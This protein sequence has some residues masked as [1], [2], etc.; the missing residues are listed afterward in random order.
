MSVSP[1][2]RP[3]HSSFKVSRLLCFHFQISPS[4]S[5]FSFLL[6]FTSY[7]ITP[8]TPFCVS[9]SLCVSFPLISFVLW[10]H[11]IIPNHISRF[12]CALHIIF[13]YTRYPLSTAG[14]HGKHLL[15]HKFLPPPLAMHPALTHKVHSN[16][17]RFKH[18]TMQSCEVD[19][20]NLHGCPGL[21]DP[22]PNYIHW[23]NGMLWSHGCGNWLG[24]DYLRLSDQAHPVKM[25]K[26][27]DR[28]S[29]QICCF[30]NI[31]YLPPAFSSSS[32]LTLIKLV[33][34]N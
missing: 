3:A 10:P 30:R 25:T 31:F 13:R 8:F 4:L 22:P 6:Q 2:R 26:R 23:E 27:A 21:C 16:L 18:K 5:N 14:Q 9:T 32:T 11:V 24:S 17:V 15:T 12:G 34:W 29:G 20:S 7:R 1:L 33:I 19:V 28:P